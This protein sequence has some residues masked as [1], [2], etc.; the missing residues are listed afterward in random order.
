MRRTRSRAGFTLIEMMFVVSILGILSALAIPAFASMIARSKTSEVGGNLSSMYKLAASYYASERSNQGSTTSVAGHCTVDDAMPSPATPHKFKQSFAA[1]AS[2][3]ELGFTIS[4][5]VYFQ[6]GLATLNGVSSCEHA[7]NSS[8]LYT[9][10][11][12]GDLDA[13][14]IRSTFELAAGTDAFN[15]LYHGR[16]LY[17]DRETE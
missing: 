5:M 7:A 2:F 1:D 13:D 10:F 3:R 8:G 12:H 9:F 14:G 17:I 15:L 6:Y 4:D 16:G 11:A